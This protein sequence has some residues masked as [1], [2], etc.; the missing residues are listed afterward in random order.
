[1][2]CD[3]NDADHFGSQSFYEDLQP[4]AS[5]V[6]LVA[7][8]NYV[9]L[10]D[11]WIVVVT[12]I[13][14]SRREIEEGN[15]KAVNM[16]GASIIAA[17]KNMTNGF[18]FPFVF[19]GDGATL[20]LPSEYERQVTTV[21]AG[22]QR[23]AKEEFNL[24]LRAGVLRV[25]AIRDAGRDVCVAKCA[26]SDAVSY[27][28]FSGGGVSWL[29][30]KIKSGQV[31]IQTRGVVDPPNLSGLS[32]RWSNLRSINGNIVS[33]V[34]EPAS[35]SDPKEFSEIAEHVL[36]KIYQNA[37]T[38]G[39]VPENGPSVQF[40]PPGMDIEARV[41]RAG[42]SFLRRYLELCFENL[43]AWFFFQSGWTVGRFNPG[44]YAQQVS[45]NTDHQK[46]EDGLKMTIDCDDATVTW[47]EGFLSTLKAEQ[48]IRYG[49]KVQSEALVTCIVPSPLDD[50]HIHFVDGASGGYAAA[51]SML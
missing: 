17:V 25:S 14:T 33:M 24:G 45:R 30:K 43:L 34:L 9:P 42:K 6:E 41:S 22:L 16:V 1:M 39:P 48:K 46:F 8:D 31:T 20:A 44:H 40:P 32:C 29:E 15:Y 5:F 35:S 21:A 51:A 10:P 12:D 38:R 4:V 19:G 27:A 37:G 49:L 13:V 50:D 26:V 28:A 2:S 11:D 23:W 3:R 36:Q 47:V 18:A 7:A